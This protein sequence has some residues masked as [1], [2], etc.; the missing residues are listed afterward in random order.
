MVWVVKDG[1]QAF[2]T[3]LESWLLAADMNTSFH[4][5]IEFREKLQYLRSVTAIDSV[6]ALFRTLSLACVCYESRCLM[7]SY[8]LVLAGSRNA[9]TV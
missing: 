2:H 3:F 5:R 7:M 4:V 9:L 6:L 1:E 8:L